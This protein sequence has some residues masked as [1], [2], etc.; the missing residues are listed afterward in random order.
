ML[1]LSLLLSLLD[2]R[3][4]VMLG[5]E[6]RPS[7]PNLPSGGELGLQR[8]SPA[9]LRDL[10]M[11]V[12]KTGGSTISVWLRLPPLLPLLEWRRECPECLEWLLWRE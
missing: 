12:S 6:T 9:S 11:R 10:I 4:C 8:R 1:V 7:V 2:D 3:W 5:M